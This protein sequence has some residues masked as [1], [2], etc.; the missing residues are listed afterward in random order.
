MSGLLYNSTSFFV[1]FCPP[2]HYQAQGDTLG[3]FQ[4]DIYLFVFA[5]CF[6]Y[7]LQL[8]HHFTQKL[9]AYHLVHHFLCVG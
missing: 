1:P 8:A 7:L 3:F 6:I 5:C 4:S 9:G 2:I